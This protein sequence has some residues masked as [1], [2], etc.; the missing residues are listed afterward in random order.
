[1][2]SMSNWLGLDKKKKKENKEMSMLN[3]IYSLNEDL[4]RLVNGHK[5]IWRENL[6]SRHTRRLNSANKGVY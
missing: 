2:P 3:A 1:M 5:C 6:M 4:I